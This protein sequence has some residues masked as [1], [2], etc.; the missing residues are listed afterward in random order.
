MTRRGQ[1]NTIVLIAAG[2]LAVAVHLG[3]GTAVLANLR[4]TGW[5]ASTVL[6]VIVVKAIALS[7]LA[8]R[9]RAGR[10]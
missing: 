1:A 8:I 2:A 10:R 4:W 5:V 7:L 6:V 9:R 3:L